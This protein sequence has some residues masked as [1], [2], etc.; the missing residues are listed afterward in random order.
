MLNITFGEKFRSSAIWGS[1]HQQLVE[2]SLHLFINTAQIQ[3]GYPLG[4]E[5]QHKTSRGC[6]WSSGEGYDGNVPIPLRAAQ[7]S[8]PT[9]T[10]LSC[11]EP[12][13]RRSQ[14]NAHMTH[15]G[16]SQQPQFGLFE[17]LN[18]ASEA[19]IVASIVLRDAAPR[20]W[21]HGPAEPNK[22]LNSIVP[23][24]AL[25][26]IMHRVLRISPLNSSMIESKLTIHHTLPA[27]K[28]LWRARTR[29]VPPGS[30]ILRHRRVTLGTGVLDALSLAN[31]L[32]LVQSP[33]LGPH[34]YSLVAAHY[35]V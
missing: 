35:K 10:T 26:I 5:N 3:L 32:C 17:R 18:V 20:I 23:S 13:Q 12:Q 21:C 2:I 28:R 15:L 34:S 11:T 25:S 31:M 29:S 16:L 22:S 19:R 27:A 8:H 24:T 9:S 1:R 14:W 4:W 33:S 6:F 30:S 7:L